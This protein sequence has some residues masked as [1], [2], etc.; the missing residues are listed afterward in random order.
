MSCDP[1]FFLPHIII[2]FSSFFFLFD[3]PILCFSISLVSPSFI[4][5]LVALRFFSF[6]F[7]SFNRSKN[8]YFSFLFI[9]IF[10]LNLFIHQKSS[11]KCLYII[12]ILR[13]QISQSIKISLF[14]QQI[15]TMVIAYCELTSHQVHLLW[16]SLAL[17]KSLERLDV[18]GCDLPID[19]PLDKLCN[20]RQLDMMGVTTD[21]RT[22]LASLPNVEE[23]RIS[24]EQRRRSD[25][26]MREI[27]HGLL[28]T[29]GR[30]TDVE[31]SPMN[32]FTIFMRSTCVSN[33]TVNFFIER[34]LPHMTSP[35]ALVLE[36]P[37]HYDD[38]IRTIIECIRR[39]TIFKMRCRIPI[40]F[41]LLEMD[42]VH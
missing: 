35:R 16:K 3:F 32:G 30:Q 18:K 12:N 10:Y 37:M 7:F 41:P 31:L 25:A 22:L 36:S 39:P 9:L 8:I 28:K 6:F 20:V 24:N 17:C 1:P 38:V 40:S 21:H 42:H 15:K 33:E 2:F 13:V 29:E 5:S 23:M 19:G 34:T 4:Q 27:A 26:Y 14:P 11:G